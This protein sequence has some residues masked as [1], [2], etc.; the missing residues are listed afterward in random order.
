M[1]NILEIIP[2]GE[3]YMSFI[4]FITGL[5]A[6]IYTYKDRERNKVRAFTQIYES[7]KDWHFKCIQIM[8]KL[9]YLV[10][11][12]NKYDSEL[13]ELSNLI[14]QG[15]F[16][17]PNIIEDNFG[18]EKMKAYQGY[19]N[20]GIDY[21]V[22][23]YDHVKSK[24]NEMYIDTLHSLKREF[25]SHI[26]SVLNPP[27]IIRK[28]KLVNKEFMKKKLK[29][30][31]L[32]D[33]KLTNYVKETHLTKNNLIR[34]GFDESDLQYCKG[35][36]I[37][38][39]QK[40]FA[41]E[42]VITRMNEIR[43]S[44]VYIRE[45]WHNYDKL[46]DEFI[47]IFNISKR[48]G[49]YKIL[50]K[51]KINWIEYQDK[52]Y[53]FEA[54]IIKLYTSSKESDKIALNEMQ[55]VFHF[56]S[57][58]GNDSKKVDSATFLVELLNIEL[59]NYIKTIENYTPFT[60]I[61]FR[62]M[63]VSS[64][65]IEQM[66][67]LAETEIENR[68]FSTPLLFHS[69]SKDI[70]TAISFARIMRNKKKG[71]IHPVIMKIHVVSL[72]D[73]FIGEYNKRCPN[74]IITSLC[75]VPIDKISEFSREDEV[76]LRGPFFQLIKFDKLKNVNNFDTMYELEAVMVSANRDHLI[77][78]LEHNDDNL[79]NFFYDM[80][81]HTKYEKCLELTRKYGLTKDYNEYKDKIKRLEEIINKEKIKV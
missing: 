69:A 20:L 5:I 78:T 26:Y 41:N 32:K 48:S 3:N 51:S 50:N 62:G 71:Y 9:I 8:S 70:K 68:E 31:D 45:N 54:P 22:F 46:K 73:N 40:Y 2:D 57:R 15:R 14:E 33:D 17:L 35:G 30:E 58:K 56:T 60:G 59:Y 28:V 12:K 21:L 44:I 23:F 53:K 72:S 42:D 24:K 49:L 13:M 75:A 27:S 66:S 11:N 77:T 4:G 38:D 67:K 74:G 76:L 18:K 47:Q 19:R 6:F 64:G 43:N 81:N 37:G 65:Y 16:F 29:M 39:I 25:T 79:R 7:Y 52:P 55:K 10:E 80:V 1:D 34:F 63:S 36:K 61:V